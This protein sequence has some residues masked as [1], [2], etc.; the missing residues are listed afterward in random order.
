MGSYIK[1]I[2]PFDRLGATTP[3][4]AAYMS[5]KVKSSGSAS[6]TPGGVIPGASSRDSNECNEFE[7]GDFI[8]D[9]DPVPAPSGSVS[10][11]WS[12]SEPSV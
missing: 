1:K 6:S 5:P 2:I 12:L 7:F 4:H 9:D 8:R 11:P 10:E 3:Y